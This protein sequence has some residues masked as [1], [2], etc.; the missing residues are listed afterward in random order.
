MWH[1]KLLS[2]G[3]RPWKS[4][5]CVQCPNDYLGWVRC[6]M[7]QDFHGH[8]H[9]YGYTVIQ[10]TLGWPYYLF[11]TVRQIVSR[12]VLCQPS[13][14]PSLIWS[15][16]CAPEGRGDTKGLSEPILGFNCETP[17]SWWERHGVPLWARGRFR[18]VLR[19]PYQKPYRI[20]LR[21]QTKSGHPHQC[22]RSSS[23]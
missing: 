5:D 23:S 16:Q 14:T 4:P 7:V 21:N 13:Q 10:W 22:W 6:N 17:N 11:C 9:E 3:R 12:V 19:F 8:F 18:T 1:P 20:F 15:L 2:Q